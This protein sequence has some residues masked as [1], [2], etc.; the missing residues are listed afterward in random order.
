MT[1]LIFCKIYDEMHNYKDLKFKAGAEESDE[2]VAERIRELFEKVKDEYRD[3]FEE[4]EK[5]L[6]DAKSIAYVASQL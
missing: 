2:R 6:L 5:L 4:D 3:V 1:R